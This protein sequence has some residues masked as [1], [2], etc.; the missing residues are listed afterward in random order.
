MLRMRQLVGLLISLVGTGVTFAAEQ[1]G[2]ETPAAPSAGDRE[3][4]GAERNARTEPEREREQPG[5]VR[6][7]EP[8][9]RSVMES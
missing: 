5:Q 3:E 8:T 1:A 7:A 2:S 6:A 9:G 4:R